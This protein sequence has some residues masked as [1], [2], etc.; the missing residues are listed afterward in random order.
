LDLFKIYYLG[1]CIGLITTSIIIKKNFFFFLNYF[2]LII[3]WQEIL[4]ENLEKDHIQGQGRGQGQSQ[5]Q[6]QNHIKE[7]IQNHLVEE[8]QETIT[9]LLVINT[10]HLPIVIKKEKTIKKESIIIINI[11]ILP[12]LQV[13]KTVPPPMIPIVP[14]PVVVHTLPPPPLPLLPPTPENINI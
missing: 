7:H 3:K 9:I 14:I 12:H 13:T 10:I 5:G 1:C 6:G 11:T 8:T 4:K 2:I